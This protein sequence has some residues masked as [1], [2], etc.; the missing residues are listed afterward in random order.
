MT[1]ET[2]DPAPRYQGDQR[3]RP[4]APVEAP[5]PAPAQGPAT[6]TE[7]ARQL[8]T[9]T[10]ATSYHLR[11]LAS[12]GLVEETEEG[13]G[14]ERPWRAATEMHGWT[15]HEVAYDP[16]AKAASDWLRGYYLRSFIEGYERWLDVEAS[17][18]MAWQDVAGASDFAVRLTPAR[19][20]ALN[21]DIQALYERYRALAESEPV[22]PDGDEQLVQVRSTRSRSRPDHDDA[23][24][25]ARRSLG[26][27]P[28]H[29]SDRPALAADR[30][31]DPDHGPARGVPR[32]LAD[33]DRH[34]VQPAGPRRPVPGAADRADS[35]MPSAGARRSSSASMVGLV[36][37]GLLAIADSVALF[38]AAAALQGVYRALDSGPLESW[39]VDATLAADPNAEIE[40]GLSTGASVLSVAIAVGALLSGALVALAPLWRR[41]PR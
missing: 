11:K 9:N 1:S 29:D 21:A 37:L 7:L 2:V 36:S 40:R 19:L 4:P 15:E 22:S 27:P 41:S 32:A 14:R 26:S 5:H 20:E 33:R 8:D 18:P 38:A 23:N 12:V 34:R 28:L 35:P 16:D 10:G 31:P 39:Y 3:P 13:R 30:P 6:A 17:W 24:D 25:D